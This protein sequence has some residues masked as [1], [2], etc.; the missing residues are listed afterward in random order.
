MR[1]VSARGWVP[2]GQTG[3]VTCPI[4]SLRA[5]RRS[6]EFGRYERLHPDGRALIRGWRERAG[7][8]DGEASF[9]SFIYLWIAFNSWAA[10]VS[11]SDADHQWQRALTADPF[12]NDVFDEQMSRSTREADA[13][14][15]F[16]ALWP[17]FR[18]SKL[19]E[20]GIDYWSEVH[21]AR[22]AMTRAYVGAGVREFAPRCHFEHD[23]VPLDWGHTLAALYRVRC[24]LFHGEKAR[25]SENDQLVVGAAYEALLAFLDES[26]V[27][28]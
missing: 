24:N 11:G 7:E 3:G 2:T 5:T 13:T 14:R 1:R 15:R 27:L 19:R 6:L 12:L 20:R 18:V 21:D 22:A 28:D 8:K 23:Q 17:I 10:C 26:R 25:S 9:E 4:E 16:A